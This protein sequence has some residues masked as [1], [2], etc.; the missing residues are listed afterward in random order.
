MYLSLKAVHL[1]IQINFILFKVIPSRYNPLMPT[2]FPI[3]ETLVKF[4]FRNISRR[5]EVQNRR[6][7]AEIDLNVL[8]IN[9]NPKVLDLASKE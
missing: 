2:F 5:W 1:F 3:V 9:E 8:V 6:Q 4:D 7:F